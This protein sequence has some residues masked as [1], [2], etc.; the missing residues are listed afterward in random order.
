MKT[1]H[2]LLIFT[3][4]FVTVLT[5]ESIFAQDSF[6]TKKKKNTA[7]NT[8]SL[9][10]VRIKNPTAK[11]S[12]GR[13]ALP[14]LGQF[15]TFVKPVL[16]QGGSRAFYSPETGLPSF[17]TTKRDIFSAPT[18]KPDIAAACTD[19]LLELKP[20]LQIDRTDVGFSIRNIKTDSNNKTR[21]RLDQHY[22]NI[23]VYGDRKSVV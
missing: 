23:P 19:Y 1:P 2:V 17:I 6:E 4:L 14:N 21:I 15:K 10:A 12:A 9:G 8:A 13:L 18:A 5:C 11:N 3:F 20:L 22:K 7:V 16:Q